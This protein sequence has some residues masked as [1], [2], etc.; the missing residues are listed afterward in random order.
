MLAV[1]TLY[2][3]TLADFRERTRRCSFLITLLGTLFFGA[4]HLQAAVL[5]LFRGATG[6]RVHV[7]DGLGRVLGL[8]PGC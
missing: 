2:R 3:L 1:G 5:F 8:Q 6:V 4:H 7:A